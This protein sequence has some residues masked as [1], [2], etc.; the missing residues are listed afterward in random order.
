MYSAAGHLW[1]TVG[2]CWLP[3]TQC[4]LLLAQWWLPLTQWRLPL[5]QLGLLLGCGCCWPSCACRWPSYGCCWPSCGCCWPSCGCCWPSCSCGWPSGGSCWCT[6]HS[7]FTLR[8]PHSPVFLEWTDNRR[9]RRGWRTRSWPVQ[10]SVLSI[11]TPYAP[12]GGVRQVLL[13]KGEFSPNTS[14]L[15]SAYHK[16]KLENNNRAY[17]FPAFK[18]MFV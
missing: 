2:H 13:S 15:T 10:L 3:L 5:A 4:W 11:R 7:L 8:K 12:K 17:K 6:L 9:L 1:A 14:P 18:L 16:R